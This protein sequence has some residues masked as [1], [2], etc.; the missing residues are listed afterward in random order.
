MT[1]SDG[2][3]LTGIFL[4]VAALF[5]LLSDNLQAQEYS[6]KDNPRIYVSTGFL[7]AEGDYVIGAST[8]STV[9]PMGISIKNSTASLRVSSA[10]V[11]VNGPAYVYFEETED[12]ALETVAEGSKTRSGFADVFLSAAYHLKR[13]TNSHQRLSVGAKL[14]LPTGDSDKGLSTGEVDSTLFARGYKRFGRHVFLLSTGYQWMGDTEETNYENRLFASAGLMYLVSMKTNVGLQ[15]Y[16][17][18]PSRRG[19]ANIRK[20]IVS[21]QYRL[22][23]DWTFMTSLAKGYS[24]STADWSLG[25]QVTRRLRF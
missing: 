24:E 4:V 2:T 3:S 22:N 8:R 5:G 7:A 11:S 14:K 1:E 19:K 6:R 13:W 15:G 23:R 25:L 21:A 9:I 16:V 10:Y 17:K 18:Q 12:G 20:A